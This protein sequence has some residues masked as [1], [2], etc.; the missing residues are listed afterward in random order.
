MNSKNESWRKTAR[1]STTTGVLPTKERKGLVAS[2]GESGPASQD[3]GSCLFPA[4]QFLL[5]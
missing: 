2:K 3:L 5:Q 4:E 1:L